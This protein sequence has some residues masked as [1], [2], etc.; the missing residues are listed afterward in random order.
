MTLTDM[1]FSRCLDFATVVAASGFGCRTTVERSLV[2]G[3]VEVRLADSALDATPLQRIA[4]NYSIGLFTGFCRFLA[5]GL[6]TH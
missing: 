5:V 6:E 4:R 1:L 3:L 2:L